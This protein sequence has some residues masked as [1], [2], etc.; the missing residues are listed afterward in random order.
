MLG[1]VAKAFFSEK[2]RDLVLQLFNC[3]AHDLHDDLKDLLMRYSVILRLI[4]SRETIRVDKFREF[5]LETY[6]IH[7]ETLP[8]MDVS[9]SVH[10]YLA[11][12]A[13]A[14]LV[15]GGK[16]LAQISEA[17]LESLHKKM[18]FFRMNLSRKTNLSDILDDI[19]SRLWLESAP[20]LRKMKAKKRPAIVKILPN[21]LDDKLLQTL[22]M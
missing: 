16:G 14:I 2:N 19:Y 9:P 20:Q 10:R 8:W 11:H 17:P 13:D 1:N 22:I 15:N 7:L 21:S 6:I 4:N 18:R 12:S 3:A 5:C